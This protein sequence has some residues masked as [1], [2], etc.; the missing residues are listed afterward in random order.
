MLTRDVLTFNN[1]TLCRLGLNMISVAKND[2]ILFEKSFVE[3]EK[4]QFCLGNKN[5]YYVKITF[6]EVLLWFFLTI[7][8]V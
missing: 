7:E 6:I 5:F 3:K 4:C 2:R 8:M 1:K